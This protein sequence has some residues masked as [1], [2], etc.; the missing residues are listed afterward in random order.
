MDEVAL[1]HDGL[2]KTSSS[3]GELRLGQK[4]GASEYINVEF[5]ITGG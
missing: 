5:L 2:M 1:L 3:S 4:G